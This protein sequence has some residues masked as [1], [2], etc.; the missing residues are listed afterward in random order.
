[1]PRRA[2][3]LGIQPDRQEGISLGPGPAPPGRAPGVERLGDAASPRSDRDAHGRASGG[4]A[5]FTP[6]VPK[7]GASASGTLRRLDAMQKPPTSLRVATVQLDA[8]VAFEKPNVQYLGEP[9][10]EPL[11]GRMIARLNADTPILGDLEQLQQ[12]I[13]TAYIRG[14][15]PRIAAILWFCKHQKVDLVVFPEYTIPGQ[16]LPTL[17]ELAAETRCTIIAGTHLVTT[18]LLADPAY[19]AC[20]I[21]PPPVDHAIAPVITPDALVKYQTKLWQTQWEPQLACGDQVMPFTYTTPDAQEV[22][23]GVVICIDF[24]RH[25]DEAA[26]A[27]HDTWSR[28][29]RLLFVTS[30][31]P[32]DTPQRF[33]ASA[34]DLYQHFQM[35]VVYANIA[36]HGGSGVFG[37]GRADGEPL[38]AN[39]AM[40]PL[41]PGHEGVCIVELQVEATATKRPSSLLQVPPVRPVAYALIL[42]S[43]EEPE[44]ASAT[45]A[46]LAAS[47]AGEFKRLAGVQRPVLAR[48]A[49]KF[50]EVDLVHRRWQRLAT[51]AIGL[52]GL[53]QLRRLATDLWLPPDV[54]ALADIEQAL[55]RGSWQVLRGLVSRPH[56]PDPDREACT[57]MLDRLE[58]DHG[59]IDCR[60]SHAVEDALVEHVASIL[61][62]AA[63]DPRPTTIAADGSL[64]PWSPDARLPPQRLT[65]LG[66]DLRPCSVLAA[67]DF[68]DE[69][70]QGY[71]DELERAAIWLALRDAPPGWVGWSPH[72]TLVLVTATGHVVL[73]APVVPRLSDLR[74]ARMYASRLLPVALVLGDCK[75]WTVTL[76]Q[77]VV[78]LE[79]EIQKLALV[80]P[81][82]RALADFEY[83]PARARFVEPG[84]RHGPDAPPQPAL[85]ALQRWFESSAL[86]C[87]V[88]GSPGDGRTSLVRTWLAGL[89]RDALLRGGL[90]V[91]YIDG[92]SW[93]THAHISELLPDPSLPQRAALRL[94]VA[95]GNCLLVLDGFDDV[96]PVAFLLNDHSFFDG[97]ITFETRLL[98]TSCWRESSGVL[99][100]IA[101][102]TWPETNYLVSQP[103]EHIRTV[104]QVPPRDVIA[105][106]SSRDDLDHPSAEKM[107][108]LVARLE[109]AFAG[110]ADPFH[111]PRPADP[112]V[113]LEDIARA[114]W[115]A[116]AAADPP[117]WLSSDQF[118]RSFA[119]SGND[120]IT[121]TL[122][123]WQRMQQVLLRIEA[124][125]G[126][127][128]SGRTWE[129]W[130]RHAVLQ[131]PTLADATAR[132]SSRQSWL[133]FGWDAL[134]HWVLARRLVRSLAAGDVT[135]L[136]L[137]PLHADTRA[138]CHDQPDWPAARDHLQTLL[139]AAPSSAAIARNALLLAVGD[140]VLA[141]AAVAPW[142]FAN[143]DLRLLDLERARL[144][145]ADFTGARLCGTSFRDAELIHATLAGADLA[146]CDLTNAD[147]TEARAPAANFAGATLDGVRFTRCNLEGADLGRSVVHSRPP[148]LDETRLSGVGLRAAVWIELP[149][150][151]SGAGLDLAWAR[152]TRHPPTTLDEVQASP[153][154]H[155]GALAWTPDEHL[156]ILGDHQGWIWLWSTGPV[157]CVA[158]RLGHGGTIRAVA[159]APNGATIATA[160]DDGALRLWRTYDLDSMGEI[161]HLAPT[162]GI[163][164][165]DDDVVWSFSDVPR[166]WRVSTKQ[167]L[168]TLTALPALYEGRPIAGSQCVVGVPHRPAWDNTPSRDWRIVVYDRADG[169]VLHTHPSQLANILAV[170]PGHDRV[171]VYS[172][173]IAIYSL[174]APNSPLS[175]LNDPQFERP[176]LAATY[177]QATWSHDG[178]RLALI[179]GRVRAKLGRVECLDIDTMTEMN[180]P[181][182]ASARAWGVLFSPSGRRLAAIGEAGP[183]VVD[184]V[185]GVVLEPPEIRP[186]VDF[187]AA[188]AWTPT[189]LRVHTAQLVLDLN[190][191]AGRTDIRRERLPRGSDYSLPSVRDTAGERLLVEIAESRYAIRSSP[192]GLLRLHPPPPQRNRSAHRGA[193]LAS[194]SSDGELAMI[195]Q[196]VANYTSFDIWDARTGTHEF[197][198]QLPGFG[199]TLIVTGARVQPLIER[200]SADWIYLVDRARGARLALR[201]FESGG[202]DASERGGHLVFH[203]GQQLHVIATAPL[204]DRLANLAEGE[205]RQEDLG[206]DATLWSVP[207]MVNVGGCAIDEA[208]DLL[209]VAVPRRIELFRLSN[210]TPLQPLVT[211]AGVASLAISPDGAYLASHWNG[212]V[213]FWDLSL[214]ARIACATIQPSGA[215]VFANG[216]F[217]RLRPVHGEMPTL[218]G[219]LGRF[220]TKM[221]PLESLAELESNDLAVRL[222]LMLGLT[223]TS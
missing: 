102:A 4:K 68:E 107:T 169:T 46:L 189:G 115:S 23:F 182:L 69:D 205:A 11:L 34:L 138:Y 29:N 143:L 101:A 52:N 159:V 155:E 100:H 91:L 35:P 209:A 51:G 42:A 136:E 217:Q 176:A 145:H 198:A 148:T 175:R 204:V 216:Q 150:T 133:G 152:A 177:A 146:A 167:L 60:P 104:S 26:A 108:S 22:P 59:A 151:P 53:D 137:L 74:L 156:V 201:A 28:E 202:V 131:A 190:L 203:T 141:S 76:D 223:K 144:S 214:Y 57:A 185:T 116:A 206:R 97:W 126:L 43:S 207:G 54:L 55:I 165:E 139:S 153:I 79:R 114:L 164:W 20:F 140:P 30:N 123:V 37:Y 166:R 87:V 19:A 134:L 213:Q 170:S 10:G 58:R 36:R 183:I 67:R 84:I 13:T 71:M 81:Y 14:F 49:R 32:D 222:G 33:Q 95:T 181:D 61:A 7:P 110:V 129:W 17:R 90:P 5:L 92:A 178:R 154:A 86:V 96:S 77:G 160:G 1:M 125:P 78:S 196:A 15:A 118:I 117:G 18:D 120:D 83:A 161:A 124:A 220:R 103:W 24:L 173:G 142:Q 31:T 75:Q 212:E 132:A 50:K 186:W 72:K 25:R 85:T 168:E 94:A 199:S 39:T 98:L 63:S 179:D 56:L 221:W 157:R 112:V 218:A 122:E 121:P 41:P 8:H 172:N 197:N 174:F 194:L 119:H 21:T 128:A 70:L 27:Y 149:R 147:L 188:L 45:A 135:V 113:L 200:Q 162:T 3:A 193:P 38:E 180:I 106:A 88:C 66:F 93:R 82:L 12:H 80:E 111:M 191:I 215:V 47:D 89:A 208:H 9:L 219:L 16:M 40:P 99:L 158:G 64:A 210:G 211:D 65:D 192:G 105:V 187:D 73:L 171:V 2:H 127:P 62:T 6:A 184:I 130:R 109:R 163:F 44:L 195:Q 48:A